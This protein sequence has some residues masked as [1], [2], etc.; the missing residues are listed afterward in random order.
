ME[1]LGTRLIPG[2]NRHP[3]PVHDMN[4]CCDSKAISISDYEYFR[5]SSYVPPALPPPTTQSQVSSVAYGLFTTT[6]LS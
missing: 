5:G 2:A 6:E 3:N 1:S 4:Y